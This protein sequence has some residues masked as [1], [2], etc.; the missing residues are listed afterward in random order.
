M[1]KL[2]DQDRQIRIDKRIAELEAGEEVHPRDIKNLL[3]P[4]QRLELDA[5]WAN[6]K[7]LRSKKRARTPEEQEALGWK[8]KR[9]VHLEILKKAIKEIEDG[10]LDIHERSISKIEIRRTKTFMDAFFKAVDEDKNPYSAANNALVRSGLKPFNRVVASNQ[11]TRNKQAQEIE[12]QL[13]E[14]LKNKADDEQR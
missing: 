12:E 2:T 10:L 14:M 9:Q 1:P 6:Q 3:T 13:L 7:V 8:S 5:A 11:T 4:T